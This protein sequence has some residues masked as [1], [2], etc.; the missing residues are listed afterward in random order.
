MPRE[1]GKK[2]EPFK[3]PKPPLVPQATAIEKSPVVCLY[4][5][6]KSGGSFY[7][8]GCRPSPAPRIRTFSRKS[9]S[10]E[11]PELHAKYQRIMG[12]CLAAQKETRAMYGVMKEKGRGVLSAIGE[13]DHRLQI[14]RSM[15]DLTVSP[16]DFEEF[17][18]NVL[19]QPKLRPPTDGHANQSRG[20]LQHIFPVRD[21]KNGGKV[22]KAGSK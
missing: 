18:D 12:G 13:V 15:P 2:R 22:K 17:L 21:W 20:S 6:M 8:A 9:C 4:D 7:R 1:L 5:G 3:L 14:M 16:A 10:V 19:A 11:S